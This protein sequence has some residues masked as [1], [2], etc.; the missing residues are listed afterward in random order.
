[1]SCMCGAQDCP[2]CFPYMWNQP[3][4]KCEGCGENDDLEEYDGEWLCSDCIEEKKN[5]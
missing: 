1:M 2:K 4:G 5:G 3:Y